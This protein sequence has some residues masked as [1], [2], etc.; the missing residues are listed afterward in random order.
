MKKIPISI[1]I[2]DSTP[3]V[4]F[5]GLHK[6][7]KKCLDD[8]TPI[9]KYIPNNMLY[10]FCD[11]VEEFG[12]K[13]KFSI[14]PMPACK[15]D[16][17]NGINGFSIEEMNE[18]LR[19]VKTRLSPYF[20]FCP[21]IITHHFAY[22]I[23]NNKFFDVNE[24]EWASKKDRKAITKYISYAINVLKQ[25]GFNPT[26]VTS[27]WA[28]GIEVEDE[29]VGAVM[30]SYKNI[31]NRNHS[32][33]F[34]HEKFD[35]P[36]IKPVVKLVEGDK[37]IV[38]MFMNV[39]DYLW[40]TITSVK[41]GDDYAKE[42]ADIYISEDGKSGKIIETLNINS[43]PVLVTHWQSLFSNGRYTGIKALKIIASRVK[44]FLSNKVYWANFTELMNKAIKEYEETI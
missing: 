38:S 5:Y 1:I 17:I 2:D 8:G 14:V 23:D 42:I 7:D 3:F 18:W 34:L 26:G 40:E 24:Q 19:T 43:E 12:I 10:D 33:Y 30:D 44:E 28:F 11:I 6:N 27:P 15:G 13:G 16:I 39:N 22:D 21:E 35:V 29:Y 4:H 37:K 9:A 36:N 31:Y 20:D 25:A 32:W 41:S